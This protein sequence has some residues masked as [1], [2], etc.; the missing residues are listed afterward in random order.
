MT[1]I[2]IAAQLHQH[3]GR[4][5]VTTRTFWT[6]P[7]VFGDFSEQDQLNARQWL[8][9]FDINNI[10]RKICEIKFSRSSGPGGQ[11]VNK[12]GI[13]AFSKN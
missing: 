1:R 12:S 4:M 6:S 3:G 10:P 5:L 2:L 13:A 8:A 9:N 11:N 7:K